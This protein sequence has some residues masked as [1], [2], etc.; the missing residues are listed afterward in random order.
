MS[1]SSHHYFL[2][3]KLDQHDAQSP[4]LSHPILPLSPLVSPYGVDPLHPGQ[5]QLVGLVLENVLG[6]MV[7]E[8]TRLANEGGVLEGVARDLVVQTLQAVQE[9]AVAKPVNTSSVS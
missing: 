7:G 9:T 5:A 6:V 3:V 2:L 4:S 1:F 8:L